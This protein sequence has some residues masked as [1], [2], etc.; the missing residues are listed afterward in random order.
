MTYKLKKGWQAEIEIENNGS[1]ILLNKIYGLNKHWNIKTCKQIVD[2]LKEYENILLL[3]NIPF[4]ESQIISINNLHS[5]QATVN[6]KQ[7]YKGP[8]CEEILINTQDLV[9]F[10]KI[11]TNLIVY[12]LNITN[13][14]MY[15]VYRLEIKPSDFV[16]IDVPHL[17]DTFPPVFSRRNIISIAK[18]YE[19]T[20][21]L[22]EKEIDEI[23]FITG[24]SCGLYTNLLEHLIAIRPDQRERIITLFRQLI[25]SKNNNLS[26][27][28]ILNLANE[29]SKQKI[30]YLK[31][32]LNYI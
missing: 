12:C 20:E 26:E 28:V 13:N 11:I 9:I 19:T 5:K 24:C 17:V 18:V 8:S 16:L 29:R 1:T 3:Y 6:L 30:F 32:K 4:I 31:Q 7:L 23:I 2:V 21:C 15:L 10:D 14:G 25:L 22:I 27:S